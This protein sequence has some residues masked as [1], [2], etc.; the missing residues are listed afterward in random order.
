M[1]T[2]A[3]KIV[4]GISGLDVEEEPRAGGGGLFQTL[5]RLLE[6][7]GR[8]VGQ[9]VEERARVLERTLTERSEV[10][11]QYLDQ[12]VDKAQAARRIGGG[13]GVGVSR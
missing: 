3:G 6:F 9:Y 5:G 2:R 1:R 11:T 4:I 8:A 10:L 13:A 7:Q 12:Q